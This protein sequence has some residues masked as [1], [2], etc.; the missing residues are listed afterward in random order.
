MRA[1]A[2][3]GGADKSLTEGLGRDREADGEEC[4]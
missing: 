1:K 3:V 4:E 2:S